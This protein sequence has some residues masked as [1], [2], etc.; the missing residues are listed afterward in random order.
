MRRIC[1]KLKIDSG[2]LKE[3]EDPAL[4]GCPSLHGL[5]AWT[6]SSRIAPGKASP[7]KNFVSRWRLL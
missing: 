6:R 2:V 1:G 3:V 7:G 4:G 5:R